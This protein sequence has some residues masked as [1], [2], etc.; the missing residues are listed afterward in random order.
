M[1]VDAS[2]QDKA[3]AVIYRLDRDDDLGSSVLDTVRFGQTRHPSLPPRKR[4]AT[5]TRAGDRGGQPA[6][7]RRSWPYLARWAWRYQVIAAAA[8]RTPSKAIQYRWS[9]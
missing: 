1:A 7:H 5:V 4:R 9:T 3:L 2:L 6:R 8:K